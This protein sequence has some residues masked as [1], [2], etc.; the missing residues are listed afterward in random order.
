[1]TK[2][3]KSEQC[4][5]LHTCAVV[6]LSYDWRRAR[7]FADVADPSVSDKAEGRVI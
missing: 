4:T 7:Y 6:R 2:F 1:M 3:Y 5:Q